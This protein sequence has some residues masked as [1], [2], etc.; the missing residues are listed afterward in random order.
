MKGEQEDFTEVIKEAVK[1]HGRDVGV[2]L[3]DTAPVVANYS[4]HGM[5]RSHSSPPCF[6]DARTRVRPFHPRNPVQYSNI[7]Q[8]KD[9]W[10]RG[11]TCVSISPFVH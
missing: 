8:S 10:A 11:K 5:E 3:R 7:G 6:L 4:V 9:D 2:R 1:R